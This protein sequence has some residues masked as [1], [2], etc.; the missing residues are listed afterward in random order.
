MNGAGCERDVGQELADAIDEARHTCHMV[1]IVNCGP[2]YVQILCNRDFIYGEAVSNAYLS[3]LE[4]LTNRQ[5]RRLITL[6]WHGPEERCHPD[7]PRPH[8]NFHRLWTQAVPTGTI[9]RYLLTALVAV[10]LSSEGDHLTVS[11]GSR[12]HAPS[13]GLPTAH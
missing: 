8:P 7:C 3:G 1:V 12:T 13:R 10:Y 4:R 9:V 11:K 5:E 2:H 6:G